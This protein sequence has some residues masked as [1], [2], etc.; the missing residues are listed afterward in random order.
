VYYF[1]KI[2][3]IEKDTEYVIENLDSLERFVGKTGIG[4]KSGAYFAVFHGNQG[5]TIKLTVKGEEF[6][7]I[8]EDNYDLDFSLSLSNSRFAMITGA[9]AYELLSKN[10]AV[11]I[12][13]LFSLILSS[14]LMKNIL[15]RKK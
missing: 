12:I 8:L 5:D 6:F 4:Q 11:L 2:R 1:G 10:S 15:Y 9:L 14:V 13:L 3:Q 7:G